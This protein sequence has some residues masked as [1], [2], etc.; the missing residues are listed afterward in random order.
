[1]SSSDRSKRPKRDKSLSA[2]MR[3]ARYLFPYWKIVTI[4]ISCAIFVGLA[5][6]GGITTMLPIMRVLLNGDT[7]AAGPTGRWLRSG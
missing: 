1:M 6:A 4:S 5:T 7:S 3:A 2:F